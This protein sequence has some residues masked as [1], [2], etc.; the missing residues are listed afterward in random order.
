VQEHALL[1]VGDV[2]G[3]QVRLQ[4]GDGVDDHALEPLG[5]APGE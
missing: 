4:A 1:E 2:L 3:A 5:L